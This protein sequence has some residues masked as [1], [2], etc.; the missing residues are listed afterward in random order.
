MVAKGLGLRVVEIDANP[1]IIKILL[2]N[3]LTVISPTYGTGICSSVSKRAVYTSSQVS[4]FRFIM[5]TLGD[6]TVGLQATLPPPPLIPTPIHEKKKPKVWIAIRDYIRPDNFIQ[7]PSSAPADGLCIRMSHEMPS[8]KSLEYSELMIRF[9]AAVVYRN[10]FIF[11]RHTYASQDKFRGYFST[12]LYPKL[13]PQ[14]G[15][16]CFDGE[17][18]VVSAQDSY[19]YCSFLEPVAMAEMSQPVRNLK[20]LMPLFG[21]WLSDD[22][23]VQLLL[24]RTLLNFEITADVVP[25]FSCVPNIDEEFVKAF[26]AI[27]MNEWKSI[28]DELLR[29]GHKFT[30]AGHEIVTK[31]YNDA[32]QSARSAQEKD[33]QDYQDLVNMQKIEDSVID[34]TVDIFS[35]VITENQV[36]R[37]DA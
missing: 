33:R 8:L 23:Y 24:G 25:V 22:L 11:S 29:Q 19:E 32:S 34:D 20:E 36:M 3:D 1:E 26:S 15:V 18:Q 16:L 13:K 2:Y 21:A 5:P 17:D 6:V 14:T 7:Y 37:K 28:A 31:A 12:L 30:T 4:Y 35:E 10:N 27:T 9:S